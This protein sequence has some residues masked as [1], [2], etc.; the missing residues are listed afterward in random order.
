MV[1][2]KGGDGESNEE[3]DEEGEREGWD[4][5]GARVG[6]GRVWG[7]GWRERGR[8]ADNIL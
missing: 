5:E 6:E 7:M 8:Y 3:S 4:G 2:E 1:E